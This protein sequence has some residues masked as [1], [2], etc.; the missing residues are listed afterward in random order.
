MFR[1]FLHGHGIILKL[2][3]PVAPG[4]TLSNKLQLA[5]CCYVKMQ[6]TSGNTD[7]QNVE[8]EANALLKVSEHCTIE[9]ASRN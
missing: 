1:V 7:W 3:V 6:S 4:F 9:R 5:A 8:D 2:M